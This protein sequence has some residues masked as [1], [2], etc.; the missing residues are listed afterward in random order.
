L[1]SITYYV[2]QEENNCVSPPSEVTITF[3]NCEVIIPT[4]FT[5]DGDNV[6][7]TWILGGI[8]AIFPKNIVYIYNRWGNVIFQSQQG[9][10][11]TNSWDGKYDEKQMPVGS[12]YFI[13]EFNDD[14]TQNK[15]G[16][17]SI[18]K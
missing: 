13:I 10:Y 6:N 4:A 1:G 8:D 14:Q 15:T 5:P 11:E 17:V 3:E 16:I 2:V 18:I 9:K 12:Y 7:D